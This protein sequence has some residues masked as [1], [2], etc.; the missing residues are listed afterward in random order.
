[1]EIRHWLERWRLAGKA[2]GSL[3]LYRTALMSL[4]TTLDGKNAVNPVKDVPPFTVHDAPLQLPTIPDVL[5]VLSVMD[6]HKKARARLTV[7]LWT[8]WPPAQIGQLQPSD[9]DWK[10]SRARVPARR[11][12]KGVPARWL[13][14]L[15]QAVAALRLLGRVE[16]YGKFNHVTLNH[17]FKR[18]CVRAG[19]RPCHPYTLRHVFLTMVALATKDDR[20]VSELALHATLEQAR[21]YT[22]QSVDPRVEHGLKLV[23]RRL[24]SVT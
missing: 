24:K 18:A 15:P 4:Y 23:Q 10:T 8:G 9:I 7:M 6:R 12:G 19:V 2:P 1:M 11:K 13:K 16:G 14:L 3:N 22:E 20:V 17:T 21:R 5:K